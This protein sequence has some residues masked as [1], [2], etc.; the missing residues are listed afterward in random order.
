MEVGKYLDF[1]HDMTQSNDYTCRIECTSSSMLNIPN[2]TTNSVTCSGNV[3]GSNITTMNTKITTL[4]TKTT[5]LSYAA[6][7]TT[8][9][10]ALRLPVGIS[11]D[12]TN[13]IVYYGTNVRVEKW[14][15]SPWGSNV[16]DALILLDHIN[17]TAYGNE[18]RMLCGRIDLFRHPGAWSHGV[19]I[20]I[21]LIHFGIETVPQI[22]NINYVSYNTDGTEPHAREPRL[23]L[24]THTASS[25]QYIAIHVPFYVNSGRVHFSGIMSTLS[26]SIPMLMC[27]PSDGYVINESPYNVYARKQEWNH[28]LRCTGN[29]E[30]PN[31]VAVENKTDGFN[32]DG[33]EL[34]LT[35]LNG[36]SMNDYITDGALQ[37][38]LNGYVPLGTLSDYATN[39]SLTTLAG[40]VT[41]VENKTSRLT[42]TSALDLLTVSS[43]VTLNKTLSVGGTVGD[44]ISISCP[45]GKVMA[46]NITVTNKDDIDSLKLKT[47]GFN[48]DGTELTLT[49]LNNLSMSDYVTNTSLTTTLNNYTTNT[50]L[51][52]TL[53]YY[54][55]NTSL[56]TTLNNYTTNTSF[57]TLAG[58]VTTLETKTTGLSYSGGTTVF[59]AVP[60]IG[61]ESLIDFFYPIG[62]L[63]QSSDNT[64]NPNTK[65]GGTWVK[66]EG[67]FILGSNSTKL[68]GNTGG[69]EKV[70]IEGR[71][72]PDHTH[73]Y[74]IHSPS[75]EE[76]KIYNSITD[77]TRLY[78]SGANVSTGNTGGWKSVST[79]DQL[80]IM[81]PYEVVNIWKRTA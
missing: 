22:S 27:L 65:W 5:S 43:S 28:G 66:I 60:K 62:T 70:T 7:A 10:N 34:T 45:N 19:Y 1:R 56:A 64:F 77:T 33:T 78:A 15:V 49:K 30:A 58:R 18:V 53:N 26:D 25:K 61:N 14:W 76:A 73:P 32:T 35:K 37:F 48:T 38:L 59:N 81:P 55:T 4:E 47:S 68:V 80:D 6:A 42:Y 17:T 29:I 52:T 67:R 11:I 13:S 21:T 23:A 31:I 8:I 75:F 3:T 41:T 40:R 79:V 46:T 2:L 72:L 44:S 12:P 51:T 74:S 54:V 24:V 50:S 16:N 20:D 36:L 39:T 9:S 57:N 69:N 63:Y 71:H